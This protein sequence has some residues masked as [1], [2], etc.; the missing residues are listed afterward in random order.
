MSYTVKQVAKLSGIS[1]RTLHFYDEIDL[2]KPA[3]Y[4]DNQ[5]RYYEETQLLLLQQI[6]FFR[7]LGFKLSEIQRVI[8]SPD[9]DKVAALES[10]RQVLSQNLTHTKQL[11]NT[12]DKTIAHLRGK[13]MMKLEEIFHG[14]TD[15]KQRMYENFLIESGVSEIEINRC[16]A[17]VADWGKEEW[18]DNKKQ[19]DNIHAKLVSTIK[20][21]LDP[22]SPE[23]QTL[24]Q[25]HY[26]LTCQLWTPNRE[27]YVG[28]SK[29]YGSHPD[30][31]KFYADLHP[32]LLHFLTAAMKIFAER[33]L[34]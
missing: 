10:H 17:T 21:G 31:V 16:R 12:L 27:T 19:G 9:F 11:I 25:K 29:F 15:D 3:F 24:I 7:E 8:T 23:V 26:D 13:K 33:E 34:S 18:L 28:L 5:Y 22:A 30:F 14:F 1:V 6:L 32:Q 20:K 4:G 2:L